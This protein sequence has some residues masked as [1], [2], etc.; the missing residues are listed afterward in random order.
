MLESGRLMFNLTMKMNNNKL[1]TLKEA[2]KLL[3]CHPNT[4]RKWADDGK[5]QSIRFG[6]RGDRRFRRLDIMK[7]IKEPGTDSEQEIRY[8][9]ENEVLV[10]LRGTASCGSPDFYAQDNI[11]DYI[12]V[13]RSL[14]RDEKDR[15]YFLRASGTSML[16]AGINDSSLVLVFQKDNYEN[17]DDVVAVLNGTACIK[18]IYKGKSALMLMPV[19]NDETHK[20]IVTRENIHIA[21]KVVCSIPAPNS[22]EV[23]YI[24]VF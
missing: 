21:G 4:L 9:K 5:I 20:P 3:N 13:D 16:K 2:C 19:T 23:Q 22:D 7:S 24:P 8:E 12:S 1:L 11:E 10:P 15:Y 14:I 18:R 6:K 17:G